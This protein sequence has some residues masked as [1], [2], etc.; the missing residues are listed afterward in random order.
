M[1]REEKEMIFSKRV[2]AGKRTYFFDVRTTRSNDYY[3]TVTESRRQQ[4]DGDFVYEKSKLFIY[5]EDFNKFVEALQETVDHIKTELLPDFDFDQYANNDEEQ[6]EKPVAAK[7]NQ[8]S[9]S[10]SELKWE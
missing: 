4:R 7:E 9:F 5:K 10:N 3:M 1:Q 2:R 8:D 6:E